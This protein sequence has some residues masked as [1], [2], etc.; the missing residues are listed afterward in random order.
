MAT[1]LITLRRWSFIY[2]TSPNANKSRRKSRRIK[3]QSGRKYREQKIWFKLRNLSINNE[4]VNLQLTDSS[5]TW[6][7]GSGIFGKRSTIIM[8]KN[9]LI[10]L[11]WNRYFMSTSLRVG[12][13]AATS[14]TCLY[15]SYHL[16][17]VP[18]YIVSEI[19]GQMWFKRLFSK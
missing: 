15:I 3:L 8:G 12:P 13:V 9:S 5:T 2:S 7:T 17:Y 10:L 16:Y 6:R 11:K 14:D 1:Y 19:I 4:R 18:I